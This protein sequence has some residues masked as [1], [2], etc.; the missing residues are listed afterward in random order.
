MDISKLKKEVRERIENSVQ[1][2]KLL[3]GITGH[4]D[5][6]RAKKT[7]H[8]TGL[9]TNIRDITLNRIGECG[10]DQGFYHYDRE[11]GFSL[12]HKQTS[13]KHYLEDFVCVFIDDYKFDSGVLK[14]DIAA[15]ISDAFVLLMSGGD[16][17]FD[18][19]AISILNDL[20]TYFLS[21][22]GDPTWM[23]DFLLW[24]IDQG[25]LDAGTNDPKKLFI[26]TNKNT[27]NI[28]RTNRYEIIQDM[29]TDKD[30]DLWALY[31]ND[32]VLCHNANQ[33]YISTNHTDPCK[34]LFELRKQNLDLPITE[35][36]TLASLVS[37]WYKQVDIWYKQKKLKSVIYELIDHMILL[38][39]PNC[40]ID[41]I[42]LTKR[43]LQD[44][45]RSWS[46]ICHTIHFIN[47]CVEK[48][49]L[50]GDLKNLCNPDDYSLFVGNYGASKIIQDLTWC[51]KVSITHNQPEKHLIE[52]C[53]HFIGTPLEVY[54]HLLELNKESI[55]ETDNVHRTSIAT[56]N[57]Q[58]A[59]SIENIISTEYEYVAAFAGDL[60]SL[61]GTLVVFRIKD[62]IFECCAIEEFER[63]KRSQFKR[64]DMLY[65]L[66]EI[67]KHIPLSKFY[68]DHLN[69]LRIPEKCTL[70]FDRIY[71]TEHRKKELIQNFQN[72]IMADGEEPPTIILPDTEYIEQ[73]VLIP[74]ASGIMGNHITIAMV[75]ACQ[76]PKQVEIPISQYVLEWEKIR[77]RLKYSQEKTLVTSFLK[78]HED[79]S[80]NENVT[81]LFSKWS[82]ES[83]VSKIFDDSYKLLEE[84]RQFLLWG[85]KKEYFVGDPEKL[86]NIPL[87]D[88]V[89]I[90]EYAAVTVD[91]NV[92]DVSHRDQHVLYWKGSIHN[93]NTILMDA[94][95]N[96]MNMGDQVTA[97]KSLKK[98]MDPNDI[99]ETLTPV[100]EQ[101]IDSFIKNQT[102]DS[103]TTENVTS[104]C[105]L[106][107]SKPVKTI[108]Q[109]IAFRMQELCNQMPIISDPVTSELVSLLLIY[110][111]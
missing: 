42:G 13:G 81:E 111:R 31:H 110:I 1:H 95:V 94:I 73:N 92:W 53:E 100:E 17:T 64:Y 51:A 58:R 46:S 65:K 56:P 88:I 75:M 26:N 74:I 38:N 41:P 78:N 63:I 79:P 18:M 91:N 96:D 103:E 44:E 84:V 108:P 39:N 101:D 52:F 109:T 10:M 3:V 40:N 5:I 24:C 61:Y 16:A 7:L 57:V 83:V 102:V 49:Y 30:P 2:L 104:I 60:Y 43:V 70:K 28:I 37:I 9:Y 22:I 34:F 36:T 68:I 21:S 86:K 20:E 14:S 54:E 32:N 99:F 85:I 48:K 67:T 93:I 15:Y 107:K 76:N 98:Y 8:E 55:D 105:D 106:E 59:T 19:D 12:L 97:E 77:K 6:K 33:V 29:E 11:H 82:K 35:K 66:S 80:T 62:A 25:H 87:A 27:L 23:Q 90:G 45:N 47:W 71:L 89:S 50:K 4:I 69:F 72:G